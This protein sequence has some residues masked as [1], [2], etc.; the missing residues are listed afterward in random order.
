MKTDNLIITLLAVF[1]IIFGI[2]AIYFYQQKNIELQKAIENQNKLIK[3]LEVSCEC[4]CD[5]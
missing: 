1:I 5:E 4:E 2:G 3:I